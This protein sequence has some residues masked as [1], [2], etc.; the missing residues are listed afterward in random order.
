MLEPLGLGDTDL[1]QCSQGA[2]PVSVEMFPVLV[3]EV[4]RPGNPLNSAVSKPE[5]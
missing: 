1:A 2:K 4:L 3:L 5:N